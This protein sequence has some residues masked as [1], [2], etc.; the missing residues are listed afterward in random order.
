MSG[1]K[2]ILDALRQMAA[3]KV[4]PN[5]DTINQ[6]VLPHMADEEVETIIRK[7]R[8][9]D[10]PPGVVAISL[11]VRSLKKQDFTTAINIASKI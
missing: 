9:V 5:V 1:E 10:V 7:L 3:I 6:R 11:I 8:A 2:G 4:L